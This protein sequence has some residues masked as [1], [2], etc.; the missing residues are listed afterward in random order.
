VAVAAD[1]LKVARVISASAGQVD[2]VIDLDC[3]LEAT[4]AQ[5]RLTD[6]LVAAHD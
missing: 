6:V 1:R 3:W 2:D 4:Q 5:A